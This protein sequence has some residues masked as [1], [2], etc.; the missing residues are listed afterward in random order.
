MAALCAIGLMSGTSMDGIDIAF[1]RTDGE[2]QIE[3][4]P[5]MFVP[6]EAAFRR[7]IEA[8]LETAKAIVRREDRPGDLVELEG[9]ISLRHARAVGAFLKSEA[10]DWG[11]PDLIG[12][13]GQTVLHRP[14]AGVTVQLGDGALLARETGIPVVYDMR[15]NDMAKGGQGAPLVPAYHAALARSLPEPFAGKFPVVF[16]N[17]GGISNVTYVP[18]AGAPIAFDSG[19]GN[20]LIDQWVSREGGVPFDAD[21]VIASEGGVVSVVVGRYLQNPFFE[22]SG[23][24]SLDRN[25]FTLDL[26]RG[27]ELSDGAR[28]LAAVSA[29]AILKSAEHMPDRPKLWIVCGGGRKNPHIVDDLR[30]GA[31]KAGAKV[32]VAEE[33]GFDGDATEAE[34]WAYLAVRS[35]KGL[36]LTF[37]TTTGCRQP[38]SGGV[39]ANP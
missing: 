34:A 25:D 2:N 9:E 23:P 28:T 39:I 31:E 33:A 4:G 26:A 7:R 32:I 13:H 20:T 36:P 38:V 3:A 15:A 16:V 8:G 19:P 5:S 12:F 10:G 17:I 21:G 29:Q 11:R 18:E 27:L 14:T 24:K 22:K 6:Y 1:V 37:P 30:S 35:L